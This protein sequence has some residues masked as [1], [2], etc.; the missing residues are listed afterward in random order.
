MGARCKSKPDLMCSTKLIW[1]GEEVLSD[2]NQ[3]TY[4]VRVQIITHEMLI[5]II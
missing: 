1:E 5:I 3:V 2:I 4:T